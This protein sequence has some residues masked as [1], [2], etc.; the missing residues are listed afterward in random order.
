[1]KAE[2][3]LKLSAKCLK[4]HFWHRNLCGYAA[5]IL[6]SVIAASLVEGSVSLPGW[7]GTLIVPAPTSGF[8]GWSIQS[9]SGSSGSFSLGTNASGT[10]VLKF[11]WNIGSG[12]WVQAEYT[13]A[14]PFNASAADIFGISLH[15]DTNTVPANQVNIMFADTSGITYGCGWSGQSGGINQV[16]RWIYNVSVP[17]NAL[18]YFWGGSSTNIDWSEIKNLWLVV[19]RPGA[20]LGGGAGT[21]TMDRLQ[22]DTAASWSRQTNFVSITNSAATTSAAS[23]AVQYILSQQN[24]TN[25][26][27]LSWKEDP[28]P[29][30]WL[31]DQALALIVL[32]R[33]GTWINSVAS[34]STAAAADKL[35]NFLSSQQQSNGTWVR[36]WNPSTLEV[37]STNLWVG[38]Q[39]WLDIALV[40][41]ASKSGHTAAQTAASNN[42]ATL[43]TLINSDGSLAGFPSTEGTV[44]TWWAM[45]LT[46]RTSDASKIASY[47]LSSNIWDASLEYWHEGP[48]N[49]RIALDCATWVSDFARHPSVNQSQKG[50]DALSFVRKTLLTTSDNGSLYGFDGLGPVSIWN[51][52]T[53]QYVASGGQDAQTFLTALMN[54]QASDG[55][56]PGSPNNWN[57]D[58]FGWLTPWHGIAPTAWLYFA[59]KGLPFPY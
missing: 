51:E 57:T 7:S 20:G 36:G 38:D 54:Q 19:T 41:Y 58:A 6:L 3:K 2:N 26:L 30:A 39:A 25:G 22:C 4:Q 24:A 45:Y 56:M 59:I 31:Y 34:N 44:D 11:H 40:Q 29:A 46:G 37:L 50:M 14:T 35:W 53:A 48:G 18:T 9:D 10:N 32:T 33:E 47:L 23:N 55:S 28:S 49:A 27:F 13:F 5:G 1:M 21:L 42:A 8:T 12:N 17:K 15:G 43:A 16:D 52:G